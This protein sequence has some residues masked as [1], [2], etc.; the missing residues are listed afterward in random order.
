MAKHWFFSQ[1][2]LKKIVRYKYEVL[3]LFL[4]LLLLSVRAITTFPTERNR[5]SGTAVSLALVASA[6]F[7]GLGV[8]YK[9]YW[10]HESPG[11]ILLLGFWMKIFGATM[12]SLKTLNLLFLLATGPLIYLV[13]KKIFSPFY[14]FALSSLMIIVLY[15]PY[16]NFPLLYAELFGLFFSLLGL[17]CLLFIKKT[18]LRFFLGS[19]FL[20]FSGQIKDSFTFTVLSLIP[21]LICLLASKNYVLL[22]RATKSIFGGI[23][24][25][26]LIIGGYLLATDSLSDYL[27]V[28]SITLD[29]RVWD[30]LTTFSE[31]YSYTFWHAKNIFFLLQSE[32]ALILG[33]WFLLVLLTA[34]LRKSFRLPHFKASKGFYVI[35][36]PLIKLKSA[37]QTFDVLTVIFYSLGSFLL[38][39]MYGF[40]DFQNL[41]QIALPVYFFWAIIIK[42]ILDN[43]Q[44]I[45]PILSKSKVSFLLFLLLL[46]FLIPKGPYLKE[47]FLKDYKPWILVKKI[48]LNITMVDSN[49]EFEDYIRSKTQE[50][51]CI[52][53]VYGWN[54]GE[55]YF[56]G[57]RPCSRFFLVNLINYDWQRSEYREDIFQN[58]P[59]AIVY[60]REGADID[61]SLFE[62][63]V[64]NLTTI[65]NRCYQPDSRYSTFNLYFPKFSGDE[66]E[67]CLRE[68]AI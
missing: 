57:R 66:L 24:L 7:Q 41:Y 25:A 44:K 48:Y 59:Q 6:P 50:N 23:F 47:Y 65:I 8:P 26:V 27:K 45:L 15:S 20:A 14:T 30:K 52:L 36:L 60:T 38:F 13:L 32:V 56:Y 39:A 19:F 17:V 1:S 53:S 37:S 11:V 35:T 61:P 64:I 33:L 4:I 42:S 40:F 63:E 31:Y 68:N 67:N 46:V 5:L 10:G 49:H 18:E 55:T 51:S 12:F 34:F 22:R 28:L 43:L 54:V 9:D 29:E 62:R 58:P 16:L 21:P 3:F 2:V